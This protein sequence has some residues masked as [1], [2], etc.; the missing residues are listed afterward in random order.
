MHSDLYLMGFRDSHAKSGFTLVELM[1]VITIISIIAAI[2]IPNLIRSRMSANEGAAIG[3]M[4]TLSSAQQQFQA[5]S[6]L[7]FPSGM[8]QYAASVA[9]LAAQLPPFLD[10]ALATG[11]KQGYAFTTVGGGIDGAPAYTANGDPLIW[12]SSGSR[13]F[14][15]DQNGLITFNSGG[16]AG[17]A[18]NPV[19]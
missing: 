13:A 12:N 7:P 11:Q 14:Y 19:Q 6:V 1:I 16:A 17:P 3:T 18:D 10:S 4:R 5:G 15:T 8:G 2:A 9:Q